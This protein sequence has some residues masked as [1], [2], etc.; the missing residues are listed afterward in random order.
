MS[1]GFKIRFDLL[2]L[3]SV[4]T[5]GEYESLAST[6]HDDGVLQQA[7][8]RIVLLVR[9]DILVRALLGDHLGILLVLEEL[10]LIDAHIHLL[11]EQAVSWDTVSLVEEDDITDNEVT[12]VNG[13]GGTRLT[14]KDSY[15]F[16]NNFLLEPQELLLL[17]PVAESLDRGSKEHGEVDRDTLEPLTLG[18]ILEEADHEGDGGEHEEHLHVEVVKLVPNYGPKRADCRKGSFVFTE[19]KLKNKTKD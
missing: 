11:N 8:I 3:E 13:L 9:L 12:R 4:L 2:L 14:A 16:I 6:C 7:W 15:F 10:L 5:D 1:V 18:L 17:A 19:A